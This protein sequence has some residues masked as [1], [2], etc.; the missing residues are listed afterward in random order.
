MGVKR[1]DMDAGQTQALL[2]Q[3]AQFL[4]QAVEQQTNAHTQD[5]NTMAEM[6]CF[7]N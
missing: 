6:V 3:Q 4:Q 7:T 2:Q 5:M 1:G